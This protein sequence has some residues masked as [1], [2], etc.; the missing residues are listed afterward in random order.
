MKTLVVFSSYF[1]L[2]LHQDSHEDKITKG[3]FELVGGVLVVFN[4]SLNT[5]FQS[6]YLISE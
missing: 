1:N 4:I 5:Y 2:A 3:E 6:A